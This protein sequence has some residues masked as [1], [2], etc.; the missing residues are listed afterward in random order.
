MW[1][2]PMICKLVGRYID[3]SDTFIYQSYWDWPALPME[4]GNH[5][6]RI[7]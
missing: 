7:E 2:E 4:T 5:F 1:I 6:I 3:A